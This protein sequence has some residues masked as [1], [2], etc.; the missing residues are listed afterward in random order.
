MPQHAANT[1]LRSWAASLL[2]LWQ[3]PL[4]AQIEPTNVLF[5]AYPLPAGD[6]M[7][8]PHASTAP[9]ARFS[10]IGSAPTQ[11][12]I[13]ADIT[14]LE[15][16]VVAYESSLTA[17]AANS[18]SPFS[19]VQF[20]QLLDLGAAYQQLGRYDDALT[21]LEKAEF[22]TRINN[23]L[24]GPEQFRVVEQMV[25][26]LLANGRS[27]EAQQKQQYLLYRQQ[28]FYGADSKALVPAFEQ[29][30]DWAMTSFATGIQ[31]RNS[32][33]FSANAPTRRGR[34]LTPRE[35]AVNSLQTARMRYFQAIR[36]LVQNAD[37]HNPELLELEEKML[38]AIYLSA[39]RIGLIDDP[40]FYLGGRT[41]LTGTRISIKEFE[42]NM[43][44]YNEGRSAL[45]RQLI[46]Q[47]TNPKSDAV[48]LLHTLL[49]LADWHLL[50]NRM[51][52]A[53]SVYADAWKLAH[54]SPLDSFA[55]ALLNPPVPPQLPLFIALPHSRG[56]FGI[57]NSNV[58]QFEGYI[59]VVLSLSR[60]GDVRKIVT[61][62][63]S[64]NTTLAL[65]KR[66]RR[67]VRAAPFRPPLENGE[68]MATD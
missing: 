13:T 22:L 42:V 65:E 48:A 27:M 37:Y 49:N 54:T 60:N 14:A 26:T 16:T 36:T 51:D 24:Y 46:Y 28:Q 68:P 61:T 40:Q 44:A 11:V 21:T 5:E 66:L 35:V 41:S 31:K 64:D 47:E 43:T 12:D 56:A 59:D 7:P 17:L 57:A 50:F 1:L 67:L 18:N 25:E 10:F 52:E 33:G 15:A 30:G 19:P 39:H 34:I 63:K 58:Q 55:P 23:G 32:I 8:L 53:E 6:S 2:V 3:L 29:M 9:V 20:E 4:L 62:G 38:Q 45:Q